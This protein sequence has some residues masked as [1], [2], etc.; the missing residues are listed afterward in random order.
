M[1]ISDLT[2]LKPIYEQWRAVGVQQLNG[3]PGCS[4]L[5]GFTTENGPF[6]VNADHT[7][8]RN[9]YAWN[10]I[11]NVIFLEAPSGNHSIDPSFSFAHPF[12]SVGMCRCWF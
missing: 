9:V 7:L 10:K 1:I 8:T 3:G 5:L 11:A 12:V 4:S 6:R 2:L